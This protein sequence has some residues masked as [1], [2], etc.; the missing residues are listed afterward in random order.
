MLI[1]HDTYRLLLQLLGRVSWRQEG[2][3]AARRQIRIVASALAPLDD[4]GASW[5]SEEARAAKALRQLIRGE[6]EFAPLIGAMK[7]PRPAADARPHQRNYV[8]SPK[9]PAGRL[10]E[11]LPSLQV[12]RDEDLMSP[13][14]LI[15]LLKRLQP[16]IIAELEALYGAESATRTDPTIYKLIAALAA[17]GRLPKGGQEFLRAA[18]AHELYARSPLL[19]DFQN[20]AADEPRRLHAELDAIRP[21]VER[22]QAH[23]QTSRSGRGE[24]PKLSATTLL[25]AL[26]SGGKISQERQ[27]ALARDFSALELYARSPFLQ[28]LS[29]KTLSSRESLTARL[30][31]F[32]AKQA[33]HSRN[34]HGGEST[35][36]QMILRA[37]ELHGK[38][39]QSSMSMVWTMRAPD[40]LRRSPTLRSV[41]PEVLADDGATIRFLLARRDRIAVENAQSQ[42]KLSPSAFL[43]PGAHEHY[44]LV[45][46][47]KALSAGGLLEKRRGEHLA[48]ERGAPIE[49]FLNRRTL[50]EPEIARLQKIVTDQYVTRHANLAL[51]TQLKHPERLLGRGYVSQVIRWGRWLM[52]D[53]AIVLRSVFTAQELIEMAMLPGETI[54]ID[55]L[56]KRA[57]DALKG[58]ALRAPADPSGARS[59]VVACLFDVAKRHESKLGEESQRGAY[60]R[61][62][63]QLAVWNQDALG[64]SAPAPLTAPHA[65]CLPAA[66]PLLPLAL[67][68]GGSAL[69]R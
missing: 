68:R 55:L 18:H 33:P 51:F 30:A 65:T 22:E 12:I 50:L 69:A 17:G 19:Q 54:A 67:F 28:H 23:L 10:Y 2:D 13:W 5:P 27:H 42:G 56:N 45:T 26:V 61:T 24:T 57:I 8:K 7:P 62:V 32:S 53:P 21:S 25:L 49:Y 43:F 4:G 64:S 58:A 44:A 20:P 48:S 38:L 1:D 47:I 37:L 29:E 59:E 11:K 31:A 41:S 40:L 36:P 16:A 39:P 34:R 46:L 15:P 60:V 14:S 6:P 3:A 63:H 35:S 66:L 9:I 52:N